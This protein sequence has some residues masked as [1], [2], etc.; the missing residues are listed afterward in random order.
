MKKQ[1]NM[2]KNTSF[3]PEGMIAI[4]QP[5]FNVIIADPPWSCNQIGNYGA[6]KHYDLMTQEQ[7]KA[8]PIADLTAENAVLFLWIT[9]GA[10]G[11]HAGEEV[12]KAWGFDYKDDLMEAFKAAFGRNYQLA[13]TKLL[14]AV[15]GI[16][17]TISVFQKTKESLLASENQLRLANNKA[18]DLSIKR[19]TKG[20]PSV[21]KL[22][23]EVNEAQNGSEAITGN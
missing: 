14:D 6:C 5:K 17:K 8:M 22:L 15:N 1:K 18:E 4:D 10:K 7:I 20:A 23:A 12:M 13:S 21:A 9:S 11:R 2:V 3:N 16:D 19:L